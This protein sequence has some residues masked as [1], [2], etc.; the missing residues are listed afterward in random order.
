MQLDCGTEETQ[1][2]IFCD[3]LP[4]S[5]IEKGL[6][7]LNETDENRTKEIERLKKFLSSELFFISFLVKI[8]LYLRTIVYFWQMLDCYP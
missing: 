2:S 6:R 7:E 4:K 3:D 5:M 8:V 1:F